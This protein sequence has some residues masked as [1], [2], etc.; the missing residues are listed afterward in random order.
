[1]IAGETETILARKVKTDYYDNFLF[2][3]K[4]KKKQLTPEQQQ[5][6]KEKRK[7]FWASLGGEFKET[8]T[9]GSL[10]TAFGPQATELPSDFEVG[11]VEDDQKEEEKE[12]KGIP[13]GIKIIGGIAIFSIVVYG[14]SKYNKNKALKLKQN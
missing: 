4:K 5:E 7:Q 6:R 10:L 3:G 9:V 8:G 14:V 2:F 13:L 1:M 11:V 12:K